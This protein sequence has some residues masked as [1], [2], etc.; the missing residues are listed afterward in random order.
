MT[1]DAFS[2]RDVRNK[3][4]QQVQI[5]KAS[6]FVAINNPGKKGRVHD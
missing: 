3:D 4:E 1:C 6:M 2:T 5:T